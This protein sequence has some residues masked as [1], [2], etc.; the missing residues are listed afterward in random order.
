MRKYPLALDAAPQDGRWLDDPA[1]MKTALMF[2]LSK[3]P[4]DQLAE[5]DDHLTKGTTPQATD[6]RIPA[7]KLRDELLL[8][9]PRNRR[10]MVDTLASAPGAP[11]T[12]DQI[13]RQDPMHGRSLDERFPN[14]NRLRGGY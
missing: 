11:L 14:L 5:L 8:Y 3:L 10:A 6:S 12:M 2:L 13:R 9:T 7:G 4:P 1:A